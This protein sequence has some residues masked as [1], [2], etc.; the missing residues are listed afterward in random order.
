MVI[1]GYKL[2]RKDSLEVQIERILSDF[3]QHMPVYSHRRIHA[4]CI[5][6]PRSGTHS[7]ATM[8]SKRYA[9]YHEPLSHDTIVHLLNYLLGN[10]S[11]QQ[12]NALL[13]ARD[14][15][16]QLEMEASHMLH[17]VID[18]VVDLFPD[19]KF[20]LTIRDPFSWLESEIN[21]NVFTE[22]CPIWKALERYR[23]GR[24]NRTFEAQERSLATIDNVYPISSYLSYW[25]DHYTLVTNRVPRHRLFLL[26]THEI[27]KCVIPLASFLNIEPTSIDIEQCHA[28]SNTQKSINLYSYVSKGFVAEQVEQYCGDIV[29]KIFPE[30]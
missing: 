15:Y 28:A 8:F 16:L 3:Y 17:H 14:K 26:K 13:V 6:L 7:M 27:H 2:S 5:G 19:A 18:R 21:Q 11:S 23:Y 1:N 9:A 4:Y 30:L 22:H 25:K 20:I 29:H 12:F 24:Y 10:Y